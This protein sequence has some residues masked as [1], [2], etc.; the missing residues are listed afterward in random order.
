MFLVVSIILGH[1]SY[2]HYDPVIF[3]PFLSIWLASMYVSSD[4]DSLL[5]FGMFV[6]G[7]RENE[8]KKL[9]IIHVTIT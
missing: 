9:N 3:P 5:P 1:P 4:S 7:M 6:G 2:Q 8:Q